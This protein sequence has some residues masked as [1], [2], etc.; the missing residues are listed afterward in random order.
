[1]RLRIPS[2]SSD[3]YLYFVALDSTD[4]KTREAG[5]SSFTVV[6]SR[7]GAA[8]AT[9]TTPTISEID[10]T[11]MPGVY[12]LL[13][14]EDMTIGSGHDTE[15]VCVHI[16]HAG[17][18]P[19]T[20]TY[21]LYR[22]KFTEGETGT[23]GSSKV[24][25][26]VKG[27]DANTVTASAVADVA[28]DAGAIA[29]DAI[30]SAKIATGAIDA[31]AI[32]ADAI[33]AAKVAADV[34]AE[35]ADAVW[36]EAAS[37]HVSAGSFGEQCGTDIDAILTDTGTTLQGEVDGIQAD[38]EDIQSRLPAALV[39]GRIDSSVG[40]MAAN[41][42][43]ASALQADAATEVATAVWAAVLE[44]GFDASKCVRI[45]AAA[46]AGKVSGGPD[47]PVFRNLADSQDQITG[48][49]DSSG[50]RTAATYGS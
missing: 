8:D 46:V 32:A 3:R 5:F 31:D 35:A 7:N 4:L 48:E 25:A 18:A 47:E 26:Q 22:P 2:G 20:R 10:G 37:G 1:M 16:T 39:S 12:A 33:T 50:N 49:A 30:T 36:D 27:M 45:I 11:T 43:T 42:L 19:V 13:L 44:T 21:E 24:D 17:M 40:A 38:T 28:I 14:D 41:T 9:Y 15:E 23:M 6:R 34:H 29:S